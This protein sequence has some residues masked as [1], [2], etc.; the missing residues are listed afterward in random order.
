MNKK[1]GIGIA[2]L[3]TVGE[4]FLR[5]LKKYKTNKKSISNFELVSIAVKNLKKKRNV[6]ISN[7]P[8]IKDTISLASN[9]KID[10][11]IE[12]IGGSSGIAYKLVKKA[13]MNGKNII[14]AN[15]ALLAVHGNELMKIAEKND[16][17]ISYEASIAGGIPIVKAIREN[18]RF[19]DISKVYGILNGTC[20]YILT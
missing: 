14:T 20:N 8:L 1:L 15:K 10:V 18:L 13:L 11:V 6:G 3:G 7:L 16:C 19:N 17:F 2:G 12:L 9:P 5:Q 4:G